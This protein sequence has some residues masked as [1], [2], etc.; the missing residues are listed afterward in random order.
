MVDGRGANSNFLRKS[1]K[2]DWQYSYNP[3]TDQHF[4]DLNEPG[5]G[6]YSQKLLDLRKSKNLAT[7]N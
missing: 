3:D 4:F 5:W 1:L 6:K 7:D 2:R